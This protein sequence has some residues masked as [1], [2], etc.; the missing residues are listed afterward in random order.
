[1]KTIIAILIAVL[2]FTA[3]KAQT[4]KDSLPKFEMKTY[5]LV[6][7]LKGPNRSQD[8][9]T[10]ANIQKGH[11]AHI[12]SMY[13]AGKCPMAGP[14]LDDGHIRGI[15]ILTAASLEEAKK[16]M[17][18]DPAVQAGRLTFEVHPWMAARGSTLP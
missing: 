16:L 8:S 1:M 10:A 5:Y 18:K 15:L 7:Y 17:E 12:D 3:A 6:F 2:A 4:A 11:L 14:L 13:K 9:L